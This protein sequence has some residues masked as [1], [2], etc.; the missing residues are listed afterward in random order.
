[1]PRVGVKAVLAIG[2]LGSAAGL[3]IASCIHADS[4]YVGAIL[5]GIIVFGGFNGLCYPA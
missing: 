5:L 4:S 3:W 1:M 2:Y